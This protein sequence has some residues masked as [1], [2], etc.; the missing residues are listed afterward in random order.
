MSAQPPRSG[1]PVAGAAPGGGPP[2]GLI[3][4]PGGVSGP[5]GGLIAPLPQPL[6]ATAFA[7]PLLAVPPSGA[8][9][10]AAPPVLAAPDLRATRPASAAAAAPSAAAAPG[11]V[12]PPGLRPTGGTPG[13]A[14][15]LGLRPIG[16]S[17]GGLAPGLGVPG[18]AA[19]PPA[20]GAPGGAAPL[21][22]PD[23]Q[24]AARAAMERV[25]A[26]RAHPA[27]PPSASPHAAPLP[28]SRTGAA[29]DLLELAQRARVVAEAAAARNRSAPGGAIGSQTP[30]VAPAPARQAALP[31]VAARSA[32][33]LPAPG[34]PAPHGPPPGV[35]AGPPPGVWAGPPPGV[36]AG[37]PP[38]VWVGPPPRDW[39]PLGAPPG[40][41]LDRRSWA[42]AAAVPRQRDAVQRVGDALYPLVERIR[43][44]RA[45]WV[46]VVA[47]F[48][49]TVPIILL[50]Q[51]FDVRWRLILSFLTV[52]FWIQ[53]FSE[54]L[55]G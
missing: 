47:L 15:P 55:G 35:W 17:P 45:G 25:L 11:A 32:P 52:I 28:A 30:H 48:G 53:L 19:A 27:S 10:G 2:G 44:S 14:A 21:A 51:S 3:G 29:P 41:P 22:L 24:G 39:R 4:P 50:R 46:G 18:G 7:G 8:P 37:P 5:P 54:L 31:A 1:L 12:A 42:G 49:I 43:E 13:G 26:A 9:G 38:G 16:G 20:L 36:W 34:L 23:L 40:P 33:E 6:A